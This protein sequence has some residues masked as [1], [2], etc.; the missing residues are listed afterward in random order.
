[1]KQK[2]NYI[3]NVNIYKNALPLWVTVLLKSI[4]IT[5][6]ICCTFVAI[7]SFIYI[8]TTVEGPS[9]FPS[10]NASCDYQGGMLVEGERD[11]VYINRFVDCNYGDIIVVKNPQDAIEEK[12]VIKRLIAKGGDKVAVVE[13]NDTFKIA[14]IKKD[15]EAIEILEEEYLIDISINSYSNLKYTNLKNREEIKT[16]SIETIYGKVDF[17]EIPE[18]QIFYL[19]DNRANSL[20]CFDYGSVSHDKYVGRV[21]I[22]AKE[23][24]QTF[25]Y[26]FLYYWH[27][28]F[29]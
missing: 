22:I 20:D 4:F 15:S 23:G 2:V 25:S 29:G 9:M 28:I 5:F 7:F 17:I 14:V 11:I 26:I 8:K 13:S 10:L 19:G 18:G 27:K 21:D 12:H 3:K 1:M 6:L 16:K 24:K